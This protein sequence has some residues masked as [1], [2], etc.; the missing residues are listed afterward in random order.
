MTHLHPQT[1]KMLRL[2]VQHGEVAFTNTHANRQ[3][4]N[5]LLARHLA[6]TWNDE[7]VQGTGPSFTLLPTPAGH[8]FIGR[9]TIS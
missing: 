9:S 4:A 7:P 2:I 8:N 1:Y 6:R 5:D 3:R